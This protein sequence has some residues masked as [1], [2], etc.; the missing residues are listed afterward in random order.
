MSANIDEDW[1]TVGRFVDVHQAFV[2]QSCLHAAGVPAEVA[3]AHMAQTH[4]L[5]AGA[6]PA[7]LQVPHSWQ[8]Q[9]SRVLEAFERGDF[10]LPD[11]YDSGAP[12]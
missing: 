8:D 9:A 10:A 1:V 11:D 12:E 4:S 5:L 6:I 7:R 2:L 3:D